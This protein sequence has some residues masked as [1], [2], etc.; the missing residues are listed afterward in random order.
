MTKVAY[1]YNYISSSQ[2]SLAIKSID[3]TTNQIVDI[4]FT[5]LSHY[6]QTASTNATGRFSDYFIAVRNFSSNVASTVEE[7][8]Q[9]AGNQIVYFRG[10][11]LT[12]TPGDYIYLYVDL[13][14]M[15]KLVILDVFKVNKTFSIYESQFGNV[16]ATQAAPLVNG[17]YIQ[18]T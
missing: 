6:L 14:Y 13:S 17:P 18:F 2:Y 4:T 9:Y 11:N 3:Y 12:A 1:T 8:F 16:A 15:T 7:G 10:R 5:D